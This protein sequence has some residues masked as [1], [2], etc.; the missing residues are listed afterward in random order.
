[1]TTV[2]IQTKTGNTLEVGQE[3]LDALQQSLC[4]QICP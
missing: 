2:V 1:M 3:Q 4:D